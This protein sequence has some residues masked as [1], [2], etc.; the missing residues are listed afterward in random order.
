MAS[1]RLIFVCVCVCS[2]FRR[3]ENDL[4]DPTWRETI[5]EMGIGAVKI[6]E[7]RL[8][9]LPAGFFFFLSRLLCY[10]CWRHKHQKYV[11]GGAATVDILILVWRYNSLVLCKRFLRRQWLSVRWT[12]ACW[13]RTS[14][15]ADLPAYVSNRRIFCGCSSCSTRL[16]LL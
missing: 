13:S 9:R 15:V 16:G 11:A 8:K 1:I 2:S 6:S 10:V 12:V 3:E 5:V 14:R 7:R 4:R